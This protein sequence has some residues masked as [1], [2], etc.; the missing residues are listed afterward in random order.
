M[1]TLAL[2]SSKVYGGRS[3]LRELLRS[4]FQLHVCVLRDQGGIWGP[5]GA[6]TTHTESQ[7]TFPWHVY[8][9]TGSIGCLL[10]AWVGYDEPAHLGATQVICMSTAP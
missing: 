6:R 5:S 4:A 10:E 9:A 7:G 8:Q 2:E 3:W 1:T